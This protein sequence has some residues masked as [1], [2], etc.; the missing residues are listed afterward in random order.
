MS[1]FP[2]FSVMFL[3]VHGQIA[4]LDLKMSLR[5]RGLKH[6]KAIWCS[7]T[8]FVAVQIVISCIGVQY[9]H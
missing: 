6:G 5:G 3:I 9:I 2:Q 7:K 4:L 1:C 8:T